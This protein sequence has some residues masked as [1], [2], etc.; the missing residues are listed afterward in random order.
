MSKLSRWY[1]RFPGNPYAYG[2]TINNFTTENQARE[3]I[4]RSWNI[5]RLPR[6]TEVWRA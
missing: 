3:S 6:G 5:K 4:R 2:P 1:Y